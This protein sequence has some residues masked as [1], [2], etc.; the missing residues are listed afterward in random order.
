MEDGGCGQSAGQEV[1]RGDRGAGVQLL[2]PLQRHL[3]V[4]V[5]AGDL[6][7]GEEEGGE[8]AV[9]AGGAVHRLDL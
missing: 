2:E 5:E 7:G 4:V 3:L 6:G 9:E 8:A 1:D